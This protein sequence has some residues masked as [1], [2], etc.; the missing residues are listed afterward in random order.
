MQTLEGVEIPSEIKASEAN[1]FHIL[2]IN[3]R[4][5]ATTLKFDHQVKHQIINRET[6]ERCKETYKQLGYSNMVIFHNPIVHAESVAKAKAIADQELADQAL[7][8]AKADAKIK[9][10]ASLNAEGKIVFDAVEITTKNV[11]EFATE[12]G[13]DVSKGKN[14]S[15][16]L[17]IVS[18]WIAEQT[19]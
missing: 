10:E 17:E 12:K 8:Q 19:K 2:F 1:Y 4:P 16:K 3:S 9:A 14:L 13:I 11:V 5:N 6:Y 15:E 7:A 18:A